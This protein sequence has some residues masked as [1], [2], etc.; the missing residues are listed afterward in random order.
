MQIRVATGPDCIPAT[1]VRISSNVLD[2]LNYFK[3]TLLKK[4]YSENPKFATVRFY[5]RRMAEQKAK[6]IDL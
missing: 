6:V 4:H 3:I 2:L 1:F 5:S